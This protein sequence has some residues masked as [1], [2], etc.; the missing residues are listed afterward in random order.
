MKEENQDLS[1]R[2]VTDNRFRFRCHRDIEC[3]TRCCRKLNLLLTPYDIIRLKNRLNILSDIFLEKYTI[4]RLDERNRFPMVY[5]KMRDD[6]YKSCPFVTPDGCTIYEDR[7]GACRIYPLG[8]AAARSEGEKKTIERFFLVSENHCLGFNEDREWTLE[9]WMENEGVDEYNAVNDQWMEIITS[10]KDLGQGKD[11]NR[12]IQMFSM[13]SYNAD[14]FREFVFKSRFLDLFEIESELVD[15]LA[16][17]DR[18]LIIFAF[19]WLKFSLFGEKTIQIRN[20]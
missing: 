12:K 17:D 13:A 6:H 5:L 20:N 16:S 11:I 14:R 18:E 19:R 7:P 8:R 3:F 4:T 9:E 1:F 2:P 10:D 15:K